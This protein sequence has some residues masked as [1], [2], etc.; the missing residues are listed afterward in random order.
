MQLMV[1]A[2][3]PH[4]VSY[5]LLVPHL[6]ALPVH[7]L[8]VELVELLLSNRQIVDRNILV[9]STI[10]LAASCELKHDQNDLRVKIFIAVTVVR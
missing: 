5:T 9:Q 10:F 3:Y 7:E 2:V 4:S 8:L 6:P 1:P